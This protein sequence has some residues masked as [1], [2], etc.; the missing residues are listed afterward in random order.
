MEF[1]KSLFHESGEPA[2]VNLSTGTAALQPLPFATATPSDVV[3]GPSSSSATPPK[4]DNHSQHPTAS[5]QHQA[6]ATKE[7]LRIA[8]REEAE[9]LKKQREEE[10]T[11]RRDEEERRMKDEEEKRNQKEEENIKKEAELKRLQEEVVKKEE[12]MKQQQEKEQEEQKQLQEKK[13]REE[14]QERKKEE[15]AKVKAQTLATEPKVDEEQTSTSH[16]R[17]E[18]GDPYGIISEILIQP[19]T[20]SDLKPATLTKPPP[21]EPRQPELVVPTHGTDAGV[22]SLDYNLKRT[23]LISKKNESR[24]TERRKK[25]LQDKKESI[26]GTLLPNVVNAP[27]TH[28]LQTENKTTFSIPKKELAIP[29]LLIILIVFIL[30]VVNFVFKGRKSASETE[31]L[32]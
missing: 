17:V 5:S 15:E 4:P 31:D 23:T 27:G 29:V 32:L 3:A 19:P 7:E 2:T 13:Q 28:L 16:S 26:P 21:V 20:T 30:A 10:E 9:K 6:A 14:E 18:I 25:L 12:E 1:L 11:V 22:D 8:Q 24:D